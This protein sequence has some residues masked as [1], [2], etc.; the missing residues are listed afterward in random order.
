LEWN[1]KK[2]MKNI[3]EKSVTQEVLKRIDNLS[4]QSQAEWGKMNISQMLA[5]CSVSYELEYEKSHPKPKAFA[6]LMLKMFVKNTVVSDKPYKKNSRTAPAFLITS[7][8]DFENEKR[9]LVSFIEKTQ[10]L[11]TSHFDNKESNSFGKLSAN[12]WS[13]MFYK[14]LDHHLGQFGV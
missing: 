8:K 11:G 9:R 3:F 2:N 12:E 6:R 5:H 13:N 4:A 7:E 10:E 1:I 14:H